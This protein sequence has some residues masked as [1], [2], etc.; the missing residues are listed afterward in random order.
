[1][2][3]GVS[4]GR[5]D[6]TSMIHGMGGGMVDVTVIGALCQCSGRGAVVSRAHVTGGW[7]RRHKGGQDGTRAD[8]QGCVRCESE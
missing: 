1:M 2:P 3:M 5:L 7:A 4:Y 8:A 6:I